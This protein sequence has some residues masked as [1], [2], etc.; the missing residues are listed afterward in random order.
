MSNEPRF[1]HAFDPIT[2]AYIGPV[3]LQPSP[4]GAWYLPDHTVD[5]APKRT[6]GEFQA[7]RLSEDGK[8]WDVVADYR[9]RMLWDTRTAMPVP[10]R[11]ALGDKVPKGVTLAEP[12]RLDGTTAQCNAWDDGQGLW[13]LQPD[14]SGQPLWNKADGTFA[15]PVPR[16]QSLPPSVTDHAPPSSRSLP[17]TYDD[18]SGTW[19]DVV[20]TAP[21]DSPPADLS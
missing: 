17:V 3:R 4:D 9:N 12:F 18:T 16:G 14:Y 10:N 2:R 5:V 1:A 21:E 13:V 11:L 7:L 20:P 6:A 8:R 19:V 15:A